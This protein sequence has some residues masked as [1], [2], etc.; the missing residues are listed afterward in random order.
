MCPFLRNGRLRFW[1]DMKGQFPL[2]VSKPNKLTS[3][4][5]AFESDI[6]FNR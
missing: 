5:V 2:S 3:I 6:R 4:P 1:R